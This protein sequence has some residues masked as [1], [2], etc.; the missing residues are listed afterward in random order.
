MNALKY[1]LLLVVAVAM[2]QVSAGKYFNNDRRKFFT[3]I[4]N[5]IDLT[6]NKA[7]SYRYKRGALSAEAEQ[8]IRQGSNIDT[9]N[10]SQLLDLVKRNRAEECL[11]RVICELSHNTL[12]HG[13][14]GNRFARSLLKFRQSSHP[15]VRQYLDAMTNG[16]RSRS[17]QQCLGFYPRC[18]HSTSEVINVGNRLLSR[19]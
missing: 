15:E 2:L 9:N 10:V 19:G 13:E 11:A 17:N 14:P 1:I 18:T 4:E 16:A 5:I 3:I 12:S 7:I 6:R 8:I